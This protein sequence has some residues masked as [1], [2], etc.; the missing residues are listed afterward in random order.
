MRRYDMTIDLTFKTNRKQTIWICDIMQKA[1]RCQFNF[2]LN[3]R[4]AY[5]TY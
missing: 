2:N 3:Q 5:S 1:E 4:I